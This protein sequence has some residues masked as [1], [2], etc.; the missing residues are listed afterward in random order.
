M[1]GI[2]SAYT[3]KQKKAY[4]IKASLG[5]TQRNCKCLASLDG[6]GTKRSAPF[7]LCEVE[8]RQ[9]NQFKFGRDMMRRYN[10]IRVRLEADLIG[11]NLNCVVPRVHPER[12]QLRRQSR[13]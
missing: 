7:L 12:R 10:E 9:F 1:E 3:S 8:S 13:C 2:R 4:L 6:T 5:Y 11:M